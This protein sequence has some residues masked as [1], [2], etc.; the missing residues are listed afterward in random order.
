MSGAALRP[1]SARRPAAGLRQRSRGGYRQGRAPDVTAPRHPRAAC[2]AGA[3]IPDR[4]RPM[5][6][7]GWATRCA[8]AGRA[9]TPTHH[10]DTRALRVLGAGQR[11]DRAPGGQPGPKTDSR[12]SVKWRRA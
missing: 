3:A 7:P 1:A 6:P 2:A 5:T 10:R 8:A 4:A 11:P 12:Y 9:I